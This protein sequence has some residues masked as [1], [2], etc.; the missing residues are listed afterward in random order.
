MGSKESIDLF[1]RFD[2]FDLSEMIEAAGDRIRGRDGPASGC[3]WAVRGG[4]IG[5][6]G[7]FGAGTGGGAG[8]L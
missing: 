5:G 8:A 6:G 3:C 2:L 1:D 4:E 7:Q